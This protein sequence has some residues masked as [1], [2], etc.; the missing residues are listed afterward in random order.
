MEV[1]ALNLCIFS[2]LK[3]CQSLGTAAPKPISFC[4]LNEVLDLRIIVIVV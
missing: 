3:P 4:H 2:L 1:P